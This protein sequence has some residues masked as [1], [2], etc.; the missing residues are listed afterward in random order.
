MKTNKIILKG[1][2]T[3]NM[4]VVKCPNCSR[5]K[6]VEDN[7]IMAIC[8]AC[9]TEMLPPRKYQKDKSKTKTKHL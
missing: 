2:K 3:T 8:P 9:L 6:T 1:G 7:I 4:K 5:E